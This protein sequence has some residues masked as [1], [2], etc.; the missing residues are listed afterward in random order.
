MNSANPN[1]YDG[2]RLSAYLLRLAR[3]DSE[4]LEL[5]RK[6]QAA[7]PA[8]AEAAL[9]EAD[10]LRQLKRPED[11]RR[12][13]EE[14]L[15]RN[16]QSRAAFDYLYSFAMAEG[17]VDDA[18]KIATLRAEKLPPDLRTSLQLCGHF[19]S[20]GKAADAKS[21][22]E[23]AASKFGSNPDGALTIGQ[24]FLEFGSPT[25]ALG[26]LEKAA[27]AEGKTKAS[28]LAGLAS[29][30]GRLNRFDEALAKID[31]AIR[32]D[33]VSS[34]LRVQKARMLAAS[35]KAAN[36]AAA[37]KLLTELANDD[38]SLRRDLARLDLAMGER[39][40]AIQNLQMYLSR[41]S[42]D[43]AARELLASAYD[44]ERQHQAAL[45]AADAVLSQSPASPVAQLIRTRALM[46]LGRSAQARAEIEKG[47]QAGGP[48]SDEFRLQKGF[49]L[50]AEGR[51]GEAETIFRG[52]NRPGA[53]D[54]RALTGLVE[55]AFAA[56]RPSDALR[57]VQKA[58]AGAAD[59]QAVRNMLAAVAVRA[60]DFN[61]AIQEYQTAILKTPD[62]PNL[63]LALGEAQRRKGDLA[64]AQAS[65]A[66]AKTKAPENAIP[67][68]AQ[69]LAALSGGDLPG[70][71]RHFRKAIQADAKNTAAK[72]NLA[73]ALAAQDKNLDEAL[74]LAT[75]ASAEK[76]PNYEDTL[77]FVHLKR[78]DFAAAIRIWERIAASAPKD[79]SVQLRLAEAKSQ[80]GDKAGAQAH[81]AAAEKFAANPAQRSAAQELRQRLKSIF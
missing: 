4:A 13:A 79:G 51:S 1:D 31:E 27:R 68:F 21:C 60:G 39:K 44:A 56:Q 25:D 49:L 23:S 58:L 10:T 2:L 30:L 32:E 59:P 34:G 43:V 36:Q 71:E 63:Y 22:A 35:G 42:G 74:R 70:A 3:R 14:F 20:L 69:G 81:L 72:N 75:E 61:L 77:A 53:K 26:H 47:I 64:G 41:A 11:A 37:K 50:L 45:E 33:A 55:A 73:Y 57:A 8:L 29:A 6:A 67:D 80:A 52:L 17:R 9:A 48:A 65:L 66:Q 16:P 7:K 12:R 38:P 15:A 62:D 24:F 18:Q 76:N 19:A 28:A 78:K 46:A 54:L 40:A 5:F